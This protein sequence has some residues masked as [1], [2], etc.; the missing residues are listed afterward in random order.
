MAA[1]RASQRGARVLYITYDGLTDP[2]G[3]S[4]VLPYLA[5]LAGRGHRITILSFEKPERMARDG[6]RVRQLCAD[7]GFEWHPLTYHKRPPILSSAYDA[8][9]MERA[10]IRLHRDRQ[11][12]IIHCRSYIPAR[13]GLALKRGYGVKLLFDMRGFWPD[14][15]VE[16]NDWD[17]ANPLYR[18]VYRYFKRL[19]ARLLKRA[20]HLI[21]L[22]EA[23]MAQLLTRPEL[24]DA[25]A[26][27]TVIP[28]CVDFGHFPLATSSSQA[29]ARQ[30][31]G[32][33][34]DES[35]LAYLGS[36][37]AWYMLDEMLDFFR[38]FATRH[39]RARFLFVTQ[40][41]PGLIQA[42]ARAR[43][44]DPD[45]LVVLAATRD[46]VPGLMAAADLGIF[47]IKPV[48]SKTASS[49][50]KMGEMLALGLPIVTN[51]GVGD[52]EAMVEAMGCGA[53]I[54]DFSDQAYQQALDR[55][56]SLPGR[57]EERRQRALPW[58]DVEL[59]IERYDRVYRELIA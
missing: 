8:A 42:A 57:P 22:T 30:R 38:A 55:I 52:V 47:F 7:A 44:V 21:S 19:E 24:R 26:P 53:A 36:L 51:A 20:D 46:E 33:A 12:D 34:D 14:E 27:I 28:C 1:R 25:A 11:F 6:A 45:R 39:D 31:L 23:G 49:P 17:L 29:S 40:N 9:A 5:G 41:D 16:G 18:A 10:A 35:V 48:F 4:Q 2:L 32:I 59:G 43:G 56:G 50:T 3:R 54:G 15:K 37:G 58:F 13:A